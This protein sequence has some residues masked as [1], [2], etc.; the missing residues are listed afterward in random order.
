[1]FRIYHCL[2]V[3]R[4]DCFCFLRLF[5]SS[6]S[7]SFYLLTQPRTSLTSVVRFVLTWPRYRPTYFS[8]YTTSVTC[9]LRFTKAN[10]R[11]RD[12]TVRPLRIDPRTEEP[13]LLSTVHF[14]P[15]FF[16]ISPPPLSFLPSFFLREKEFR[17]FFSFTTVGKT[18]VRCCFIR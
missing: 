4:R 11:Y 8:L 5:P 15:L 16:L 14:S 18:V 6:L 9:P 1:M 12:G 2:Q 17:R 7:L 10:H 3:H 13:R